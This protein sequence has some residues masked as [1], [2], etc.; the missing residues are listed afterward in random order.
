MKHETIERAPDQLG[1]SIGRPDDVPWPAAVA[2][3]GPVDDDDPVVLGGQVDQSAGFEVLDHAAV[4]V[5]KHQRLAGTSFHVVKPDTVDFQE[6]P[7]WRICVFCLLRKMTVEKC[8]RCERPCCDHGCE[9][10][11][12]PC[13]TVA[14][15][16]NGGRKPA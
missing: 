2:E 10:I 5:Q 12:R 7:G 6:L 1:L 13:C 15:L 3:S 4:A 8:R 16:P 9:R 14:G 11:G